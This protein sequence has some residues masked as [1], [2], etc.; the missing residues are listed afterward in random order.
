MY[1]TEWNMN[2][3][4]K[5][6]EALEDMRVIYP[7]LK[8]DAKLAVE[9]AFPEL[10]ESEDERIRREII[11]FIQWSVNRHFMREDFHQA[12]R[13]S[14]W[15]AYLEKQKEIPMPNSTE[16]IDMWDKEKAMLEEKDFRDDAWRLAYNA[17]MDGFA[18]GTC[19]KFEKLI[20]PAQGNTNPSKI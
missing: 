15:I 11:D 17:F 5:Y 16:L 3:K 19:V 8:G 13:P 6:N 18:E 1:K 9:H 14:E 7:N 20:H 2:Y 10:V 4:K 12:K